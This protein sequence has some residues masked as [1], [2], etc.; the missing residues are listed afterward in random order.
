VGEGCVGL[1]KAIQRFD[2]GKGAKFTTYA[3]FWV[4]REMLNAVVEQPRTVHVPR[5]ARQVGKPIPREIRIDADI[6]GTDGG[7]IADRLVDPAAVSP[8]RRIAVRQEREILRRQVL[9]LPPRER[10]IVVARFGLD[11]DTPKSLCEL[12]LQMTLSRER[13]RQIEV[14]ALGRL[15]KA[16]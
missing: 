9:A 7:R 5:Y 11:G 4:R 16:L 2:P 10:A 15:R 12:G 14:T 3:S 13:I 8:V 1:L 6:A